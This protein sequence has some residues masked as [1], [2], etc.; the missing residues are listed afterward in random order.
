[1]TAQA[2]ISSLYNG[3]FTKKGSKDTWLQTSTGRRV[4]VLNPK[5]EEIF[6][7]DIAAAIAKQCR[8]NG[9]CK[10]FYSVA[11]HCVEGAWIA[12]DYYKD[13]KLA[14]EFLL[15]DATEAYVGDIIRPVKVH[16]PE[17]N[18][19]ENRFTKAISKRFGVP[20]EMT[21]EC[22]YIDDVMVTW[23]KRD[24]L[25]NAELWPSL[26]DIEYFNFRKLEGLSWEHCEWL[27]INKFRELFNG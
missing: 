20:I 1:M 24:L 18:E 8:F 2:N 16:L 6:I 11:Q 15:H 12:E 5:P 19:I 4:S 10:S 17:Y 9:H 27:Y 14:K 3:V 25:P 26:P 7:E 21:K 13:N 22:K 23:E